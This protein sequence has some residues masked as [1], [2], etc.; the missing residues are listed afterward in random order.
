MEMVAR[1]YCARGKRDQNGGSVTEYEYGPYGA[2]YGNTTPLIFALHPYES[3]M[4][5]YHAP[6]RNYSPASARWTTPDPAGLI[7]GPNVYAYV[8]GNPVTY[9]DPLGLFI[10]Q[11]WNARPCC[12]WTPRYELL[13]FNTAVQCANALF[14][15]A[16]EDAT[17]YIVT[18]GVVAIKWPLIGV[19]TGIGFALQYGLFHSVCSEL[20]CTRRG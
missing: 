6:N 15:Q 5:F 13:G 3:G 7:V 12:E 2:P 8:R 18:A 11:T 19:G 16:N 17:P 4:G 1:T 14:G 9:Y 20:V 10:P